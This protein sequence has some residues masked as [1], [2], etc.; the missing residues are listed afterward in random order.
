MNKII[1]KSSAKNPIIRLYFYIIIIVAQLI[2]FF[3][4][5]FFN[6]ATFIS[7]LKQRWT[8][9]V[10]LDPSFPVEDRVA[11]LLSRMTTEEKI[12]QI[13]ITPGNGN[14]TR[15]ILQ[16]NVGSFLFLMGEDAKNAIELN[17]KT[18]L[19]IPLLIGIDAIHGHSFLKE[20][21]I[22]PS[23]FGW[24][25][26]WDVDLTQRIAN[27]TAFEMRYSGP[28][29]T[30]SPVAC[31]VRDLRW[32]R[33]D[34]S[35]GEDPY[36][37]GL[38]SVAMVK[39]LQG[40]NLTNNP[41]KVMACVKHYVGYGETIGGLDATPS[42]LSKKKLL[43][44]FMKPFELCAK[45][46]A[47][48][49]MSA[50]QSIDG[51]PA[52]ANKWLL[53]D[54]LR[55]E[56]NFNG[57]VVSDWDN[58]GHL[59]KDQNMVPTLQDAIVKSIDAG[60]DIAMCTSKFVEEG[61]KAAK[62]GYLNKK[63]LDRA[64]SRV[65]T[66]K[67]KL[68]LFEDE[69]V[70]DEE[71]I[72]A[73]AGLPEHREVALEAALKSL[74]LLKNDGILPLKKNYSKKILLLGQNADSVERQLGDWT[75]G[76]RY[77]AFDYRYPRS[78]TI[79]VRDALYKRLGKNLT[80]NQGCIIE[81][82]DTGDVDEAMNLVEDAELVI[83]VVGDSFKYLG[84][85]HSTGTL[86]LMGTQQELINRVAKSGKPFIIDIVSSKPLILPKS[87]EKASA[88]IAQFNPG[89]LGGEAFAKIIFGES[90]PRGRLTVS[91]PHHV[92]QMPSYYQRPR[93]EHGK[94]YTDLPRSIAKYP[95][96]YGLL[97]TDI[98]YEEAQIDKSGYFKDEV[99]NVRVRLRNEGLRHGT[100]VVQCY[101][102]DDY[103]STVWPTHELKGFKIVELD[104]EETK[105]VNIK[106]PV[107][108]LAIINENNE[109]VVETGTFKLWIG[110][111]ATDIK[112]KIPF[113]VFSR[114]QIPHKYYS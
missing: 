73:R 46:G 79:T 104:P 75:L 82:E 102:H 101:I 44:F 9:C 94:G 67:F 42:E 47:G 99:I 34:E 7:S 18:R 70:P 69:R 77:N 92:G 52:V 8:T 35:F 112:I 36:L 106:I 85:F 39:G 114:S 19:K 95:F 45:A 4:Y 78:N 5:V 90:N 23:Q 27:I 60:N 107:S 53:T 51:I 110:K 65:L 55:D 98:V 3:S 88:I 28:T 21:T 74:I 71:K 62:S 11:D 32:G 20:A 109:R 13:A 100:E 105:I 1:N 25:S 58:V 14:I 30:F 86:E 40:D 68:G 113:T 81:E 108:E 12:G 84:E 24:S 111:S 33:V 38:M 37:I 72:K 63:D 54:V 91:I 22:F 96:G 61:T 66:A 64:V 2:V 57:F 17:K 10:Y 15:E 50:Y 31:M 48:T 49:F 83:I 43:S 80:Y 93:A 6:S 97:Y 41:D 87:S 26:S 59:Y 89:M 56:W 29:W 16:K 76:E 103:T